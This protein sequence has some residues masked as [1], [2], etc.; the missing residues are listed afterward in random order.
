MSNSNNDF[1]LRKNINK[2]ECYLLSGLAKKV[3]D[4]NVKRL[5]RENSKL[6]KLVSC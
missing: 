4:F 2:I 6:K 1:K 3:I 5:E